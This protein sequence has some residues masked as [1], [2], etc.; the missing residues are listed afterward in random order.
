MRT[1]RTTPDFYNTLEVT[2]NRRNSTRWGALDV[3][4]R[5]QESPADRRR[6]ASAHRADCD[7]QRRAVRLNLTWDWV[8]K[9]VGNYRLPGDVMVSGVFDLVAGTAGQRTY[10]F[11]SADPDGGTPLRQLSTVTL[12]LEPY[13]S[14]RTPDQARDEFP[15][16]EIPEGRRQG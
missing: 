5:H 4:L 9:A 15:R 14:E 3:V 10:V 16:I 13:G 7:A 8:Y 6:G 1:N 11:R 2:L 12:R